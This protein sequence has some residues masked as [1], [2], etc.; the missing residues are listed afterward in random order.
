MGSSHSCSMDRS[1]MFFSS[2]AQELKCQ[3]TSWGV[4]GS[5]RPPPDSSHTQANHASPTRKPATPL[6]SLPSRSVTF[7]TL[8]L[9]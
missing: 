7:K 5:Q 1:G 9:A 2:S 8:S 4:L 3:G 6:H